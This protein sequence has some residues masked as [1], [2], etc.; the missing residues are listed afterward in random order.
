[1]ACQWSGIDHA[2]R[3]KSLAQLPVH[4]RRKHQVVRIDIRG[5]QGGRSA[6]TVDSFVATTQVAPTILRLLGIDPDSLDAV[7]S[8]GTPVLPGIFQKQDHDD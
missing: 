8:E 3:G 6:S 1:M 7:R 4:A 2:A 5:R